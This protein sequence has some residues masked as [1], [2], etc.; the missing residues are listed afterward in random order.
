MNRYTA[1][2]NSMKIQLNLFNNSMH[3]LYHS[4]K[5][6]DAAECQDLEKKQFDHEEHIVTSIN[7]DGKEC[8]YIEGYAKPPNAYLY[9][10]AISQMIQSLELLLKYILHK[11]NKSSIFQGK[12]GHT[13]TISNA[14]FQFLKSHPECLNE[15]QSAF[16]LSAADIRNSIQHYE[17]HYTHDEAIELSGNLLAVI[18]SI[19]KKLLN[20]N[21]VEYFSFN[22]WTDDFD[23]V[24]DTAKG[25][26]LKGRITT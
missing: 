17:F 6:I 10:F 23:T 20:I 8:F 26:L 1:K 9:S 18:C 25:L 3:C 12:K 5:Q 24:G 2:I 15:N 19:C 7:E 11:E 21:I 13:I 22:H 14:I 4:L 16:L